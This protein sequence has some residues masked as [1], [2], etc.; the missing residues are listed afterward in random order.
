VRRYAEIQVWLKQ[1]S[2][3]SL[4]LLEERKKR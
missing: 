2:S 3:L 4:N 1:L